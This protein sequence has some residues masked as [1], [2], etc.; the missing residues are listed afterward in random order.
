MERCTSLFFRKRDLLL[1][2][3]PQRKTPSLCFFCLLLCSLSLPF[4]ILLHLY[5]CSLSLTLAL[6]FYP[7]WLKHP[8]AKTR[9]HTLHWVHKHMQITEINKQTHTKNLL[10]A[11]SSYFSQMY[12]VTSCCYA[13]EH[14]FLC[15]IRA[16]G[17]FSNTPQYE[18]ERELFGL[19]EIQCWCVCCN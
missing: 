3:L 14:V 5:I 2:Y 10:S 7:V 18:E 8:Q 9:M 15:F 19:W 17:M 4:L 12:L 1:H 13:M 16:V 11:S 6:H